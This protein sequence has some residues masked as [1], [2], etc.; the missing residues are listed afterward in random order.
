[1]TD[2]WFGVLERLLQDVTVLAQRIADVIVGMH[3]HV[4]AIEEGPSTSEKMEL[5]VRDYLG[6][7]CVRVPRLPLPLGACPL[8]VCLSFAA[9]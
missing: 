9:T 1:M 5:F 8:T 3:A 6:N 7:K 4:I 2:V